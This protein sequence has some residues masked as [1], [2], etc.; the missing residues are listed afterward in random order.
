MEK[1]INDLPNL[2][3]TNNYYNYVSFIQNYE[4]TLQKI[5]KSSNNSNLI[6]D[7]KIFLWNTEDFQIIANSFDFEK[8]GIHINNLNNC[9]NIIVTGPYIRSL[10]L[11]NSTENKSNFSIRKEVYLFRYTDIKWK[12]IIDNID[13]YEE[14]DN[15]YYYESKEKK[16]CL[17]KKKY[18]SPSHILLQH[19]YMK[20]V[21]FENGKF[22]ISSM[23]MIEYQKHKSKIMSNFC[24][25][26]LNIP[27][28]PMGI[29]YLNEK[30][31]KNPLRII[32]SADLDETLKLSEKNITKNFIYNDTQ[33]TLIEIALDKYLQEQN[34]TIMENL[35]KII[36][37]LLGHKYRRSPYYYAT[38]INLCNKNKELYDLICEENK[39]EINNINN[40]NITNIT[41][42]KNIE[43]LDNIKFK[44]YKNIEDINNF[45]I[46]NL[47]KNDDYEN[48]IQFLIFLQK[49]LNKIHIELI[50]KYN[51]K[52]TIE[53]LIKN[54]I[55]DN[56]L[57]YYLIFMSG[58][59]DIIENMNFE[60]DIDISVNFLKDIISNGVYNSFLYLIEKDETIIKTLFNDKKNIMHILKPCGEYIKIIDKIFE[61]LPEL[62]NM[63]DDNG[64][65]AIIFHSKY[66]PKLLE[67]IL[68]Y[69][70]IDLTITDNDGNTCLHHL[71]YQDEPKILKQILKKYPELINLPNKQ[72]E[73][74]AIISCKNKREDMFYILKYNGANLEVKDKYG[75]TP[76]HY[77]CANSICLDMAIKNIPNFFGSTPKDYCYL[78][79][80]YY[81]FYEE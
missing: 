71:C 51:A 81:S 64:E 78:S 10:I 2:I 30:S 79:H 16:I 38:C 1:E 29:Y 58:N 26:I 5:F 59:I 40:T 80:K 19:D 72:F 46:E 41:N 11:N 61:I 60:I 7:K 69:D 52:N 67:F 15:E 48:L 22:Y 73:Y 23:F 50:I 45:I 35:E 70:N 55:L 4:D 37:Y 33:K 44:N 43:V 18:K 14:R 32:E 36:I 6:N 74:P 54:K 31:L 21:G 63:C 65:T 53:E 57:S 68:K 9:E 49:K 76:Y 20:R 13:E 3:K 47:I 56:Y 66:N 34:I 75:N 62:I 28:D 8:F 77:I 25:P 39:S 24:D 27:Y 12:D 17:I 42:I